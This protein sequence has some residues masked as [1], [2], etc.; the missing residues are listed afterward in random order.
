MATVTETITLNPSGYTGSTNLSFTSSYPMTNAY[1]GIDSE[2]YARFSISAS[3]TGYLYLTIDTSDIP[4]DATNVSIS[5]KARV[6]V[7]NTTRVTNTQ[8]QLF[9]GTTAKGSN[10]TFASTSATNIATLSTGS[11]WTRNE[12]NDLRMKVGGTGSSSTS[13]KFIYFYGADITI[14]YDVEACTVTSTLT[15][16]G[17][18][19]PSG[20][21][22]VVDGDEYTLTITPTNKTDTVTVTNNG[23]D[24]T[25]QLVAHGAGS[26][27]SNVLGEY[28]LI[29]GRFSSG[30]GESWFQ[31]IVG[32]GYDTTETTTSNYYS[33]D[34]SVQA[35]FQ[36]SVAFT[37]IPSNASITRMYMMANG[38]AESTTSASEY[39]CVQLKSGNT[40]LTEQYNFKSHGTSNGTVTVEAETLPTVA[41]LQNLVVECTLGYYG[42]AINGVTVFV[43][44]EVASSGTDHYT[45]TY[46]VDG[47]ATIA[48]VIGGS[49]E[50]NKIYF[51]ANG[52]W[53][54]ATAVYKKVN[55]TW[56]QQSDL[57]TVF[58]ANTNYVKGN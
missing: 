34:S 30:S 13:S 8:C 41:Q 47:D 53:V 31:G 10:V 1:D 3:S 20:E 48:V 40:E 25:S 33:A 38:H 42:G 44:Y 9:T 19:D 29:S 2:S 45:Y 17:T 5:A 11:S 12:L 39:M 50:T 21:T 6:R 7:S 51:K 24:V 43:E 57:T 23:T 55:G 56:V 35:V 54:E 15:G 14:S 27:V 22:A 49:A 32:N 36:Y 26:T 37:N 58:D 28:S 16:N 4:S 18:I 52:S 46:T